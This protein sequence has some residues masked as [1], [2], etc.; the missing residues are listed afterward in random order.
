MDK[1][2]VGVQGHALAFKKETG[3][4]L[5]QT[6]LGGGFGDSF[7]SLASDGTFVFAHTRGKLFCLDATSGQILWNNDLP[8]LGYGI[9]SLCT[10]AVT[11]DVQS[12]L[13]AHQKKSAGS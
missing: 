3:E 7:V 10:L 4:M 9:A 2:F 6:K 1:A 12:H 11:T 5:W 8:G 13:K